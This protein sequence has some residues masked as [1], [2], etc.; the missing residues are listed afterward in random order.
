MQA[1]PPSSA[2]RG[3]ETRRL[4]ETRP[5]APL[6]R[7]HISRPERSTRHPPSQPSPKPAEPP[8]A[9]PSLPSPR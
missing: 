4:R 6:S 5:T 7:S 8:R 1:P 2:K 9:Q 3:A